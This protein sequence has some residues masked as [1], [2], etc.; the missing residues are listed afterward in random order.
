[1]PAAMSTEAG[2]STDAEPE[3]RGEPS[4]LACLTIVARHHGLHLS[5]AQLTRDNWLTGQE[6]SVADLLKCGRAAGLKVSALRLSWGRLDRLRRTLP[7]IV[8]LKNGASMVLRRLEGDGDQARVVLEDPNAGEEAPLVIDRV[9]FEDVWAGGVI[10]VKRDYD[11]AD[12]AQAIQHRPGDGAAVSRALDHSRY[13]D[14]R[15]R[16]ELSRADADHLLAAA[17]GQ[18]HLLQGVQYAVRGLRWRWAFSSPSRRC[19]RIC[20]SC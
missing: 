7:A 20:A 4:G 16:P 17:V 1:M 8:V 5:V 15:D 6:V 10:L 2:P 14:L 12:E 13:R 3:A 11:I 9:R 18:G 19:S